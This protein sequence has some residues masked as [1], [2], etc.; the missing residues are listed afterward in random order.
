VEEE[1]KLLPSRPETRRQG[2]IVRR[3]AF[4]VRIVERV[5]PLAIGDRNPGFARS[6]ARRS[7]HDGSENRAVFVSPIQPATARLR[8]LDCRQFLARGTR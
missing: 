5:D 2:E 8:R 4:L 1:P 7:D 6:E 3:D